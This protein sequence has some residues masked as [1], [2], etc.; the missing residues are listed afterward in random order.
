MNRNEIMTLLAFFSVTRTHQKPDNEIF[1]LETLIFLY[2]FIQR[3]HLQLKFL[4][5]VDNKK[6]QHHETQYNCENC[7]VAV[8]AALFPM[9]P[10]GDH[11]LEA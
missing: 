4:H 2:L 11:L 9:L 10:Y 8:C 3:F 7:R 6:D 5:F 1:F